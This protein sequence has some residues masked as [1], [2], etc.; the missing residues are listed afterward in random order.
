MRK[1]TKNKRNK[2]IISQKEMKAEKKWLNFTSLLKMV[3]LKIQE[4][5]QISSKISTKKTTLWHPQSNSFKLVT[6]K[7]LKAPN[8]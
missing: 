8:F 3:S 2:Q 4:G 6:D 1:I 7:M 5:Q